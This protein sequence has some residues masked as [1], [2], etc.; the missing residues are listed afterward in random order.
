MEF[1]I[2]RVSFSGG[3]SVELLP[4]SL[5]VLLGPNNSGKSTAL[6]D[7]RQ[8]FASAAATRNVI[9]SVEHRQSG[10]GHEFL[11]WMR[12]SF[13]LRHPPGSP[14]HFA[15]RSHWTP[16]TGIESQWESPDYA[17]HLHP[18]LV[19]H[20]GTDDRLTL[21]RYDSSIN[22]I[23]DQPVRYIHVMQTKDAVEEAVRAYVR[24]AFGLDI[25]INRGGGNQVGF[26]VGTEPNR[27]R[28]QDRVSEGYLEELT[29]LPRLDDAGDGL[30]SYVGT[31]LAA[32]CGVH[33]VLMLDEPEAF[34]H[35]PQ[36]R[37]IATVL[38][39]TARA[40][41]RQI[42]VATHSTD[43]VEGAVA[44]DLPV[45]VC[46]I[47]RDGDVNHAR[48]V[49]PAEL[50]QLWSRPLLRSS[51]A[52][53][54]M[55]HEGVVL[56]EADSDC[57]LY[58]ASIRRAESQG[59]TNRAVD[60][61]FA[62]GGGKGALASLASAYSKIGVKTAVIADL[63]LLRNPT[64]MR[65]VVEAVGGDWASVQALA[66][67][68]ASALKDL[69]AEVTRDELKAQLDEASNMLVAGDLPAEQRRQLQV[70][71]ADSAEWSKAKRSGLALLRGGA[72]RDADGLIDRLSGMGVFLVP[73]GEL[74]GWF[75][76]GPADKPE[77]FAAALHEL[78]SAPDTLPELTDFSSRIL[79]FFG[80]VH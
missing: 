52:I 65:Q 6:R 16:E 64:Q 69:G 7:I 5:T 12:S 24:A 61:F 36:A 17:R 39:A 68:A 32:F 59:H 75:P 34:L 19:N 38:A 14:P 27:T 37:R 43:F 78:G 51:S 8:Y 2:T 30:K 73:V 33:P 3:E 11:D 60:L 77:W 80:Y 47:T 21:A 29:K 28:E 45:T 49:S 66:T 79:S 50:E 4:A 23:N 70:A 1:Q 46:R 13:P 9:S 76:Q 18:F 26:H 58:E 40:H 74:E 20:L 10:T 42:I 54:G 44:A 15:T 56:C 62:H 63:D 57:R 48:S 71:L 25:L 35:P 67:S 53:S 31:I 55:F 41:G 22:L 72:R